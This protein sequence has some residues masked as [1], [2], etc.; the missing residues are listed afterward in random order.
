V[1]FTLTNRKKICGHNC[2]VPLG[3]QVVKEIPLGSKKYP[4][5]VAVVDDADFELVS[6]RKWCPFKKSSGRVYAQTTVFV[7]GAFTTLKMH[8]LIFRAHRP[9]E[10]SSKTDVGHHDG[11]GLNCHLSNLRGAT[12]SENR[13]SRG[14]YRNNTSGYKGVS[15]DKKHGKWYAKI[16]INGDQN[17]L[18]RFDTPEAAYAA[19]YRAAAE[20]HGESVN[21]GIST[22]ATT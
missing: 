15:W 2:A 21:I 14:T 5:L 18:G 17:Y 11:D 12:R 7:G 22:P 10:W 1:L 9:L 6:A 8:I 16:A 13:R 19:Y 4:G 20:L 3:I